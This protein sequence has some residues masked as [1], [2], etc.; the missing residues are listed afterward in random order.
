MKIKTELRKEKI[1]ERFIGWVLKAQLNWEEKVALRDAIRKITSKEGVKK[2]LENKKSIYVDFDKSP[3]GYAMTGK[4][5][6]SFNTIITDTDG[7]DHDT[8]RSILLFD[9]VIEYNTMKEFM[10]KVDF[11]DFKGS[12]R[13]YYNE[14]RREGV[15]GFER[16]PTNF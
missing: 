9:D 2:L 14:K 11:V 13:T 6:I 10:G 8:Y 7:I 16:K 5:G 3:L 4:T 12:L 1:N 15:E